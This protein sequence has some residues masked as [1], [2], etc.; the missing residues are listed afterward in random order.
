MGMILL[1]KEV[2]GR[3]QYT[4]DLLDITVRR[5]A[6]GAQVNSFEDETSIKGIDHPVMGVY[7]RAPIV[8][9]TGPNVQTLATYEDSIV[10][11]RQGQILGTSFHP[12]L[13]ED[14]S[15]HRWFLEF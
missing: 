1:A 4:L 10:A 7:I 2:E 11:V 5:N 3:D 6:F 12:E 9:R 15:L 13:T 14:I 8:T